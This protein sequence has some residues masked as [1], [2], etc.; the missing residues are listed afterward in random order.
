M[1]MYLFDEQPIVANKALARALG[2]NEDKTW[3]E[4]SKK[5]YILDE[6]G[7]KVKLKNC[8]YKIKKINTVD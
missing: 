8:N 2:L 7:K 6:N 1:S 5:E 4:K 3:R